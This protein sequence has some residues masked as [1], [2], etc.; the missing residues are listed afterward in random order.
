MGFQ[1]D[2]VRYVWRGVLLLVRLLEQWWWRPARLWGVS[3]A[4][5]AGKVR[6]IEGYEF[7]SFQRLLHKR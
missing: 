4:G 5:R 2:A 7:D 3:V 6:Q 1:G